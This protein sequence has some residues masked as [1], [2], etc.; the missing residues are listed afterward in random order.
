MANEKIGPT[1]AREVWL[2]EIEK[3]KQN[4]RQGWQAAQANEIWLT[5]LKGK[6]IPEVVLK[7]KVNKNISKYIRRLQKKI[8]L[9]F[10]GENNY[11]N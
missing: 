9:K 5:E 6:E 3:A 8:E 7:G 2:Q 4:G 10:Y 1:K 11:Y